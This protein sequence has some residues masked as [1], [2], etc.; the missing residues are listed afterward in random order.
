MEAKKNARQV[1]VGPDGQRK[2]HRTTRLFSR[3]NVW[4][5][6]HELSQQRKKS[7]ETKKH[8]YNRASKQLA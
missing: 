4:L 5:I 6:G 1:H 8:V 2:I 3:F 7:M